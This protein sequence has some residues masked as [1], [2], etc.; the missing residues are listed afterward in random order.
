MLEF[1]PILDTKSAFATMMGYPTMMVSGSAMGVGGSMAREQFGDF[2]IPQGNA[3]FQEV[4]QPMSP[5]N[6]DWQD[7][8]LEEV[9]KRGGGIGERPIEPT[10]NKVYTKYGLPKPEI[11]IAKP[12]KHSLKLNFG[13]GSH[14]NSQGNPW[15]SQFNQPLGALLQFQEQKL[16][17]AGYGFL[18]MPTQA[19]FYPWPHMQIS[20]DKR[21]HSEKGPAIIWGDSKEEYFYR[22]IECPQWLITTPRDELNFDHLSR[23]RNAEHRRIILDFC[24]LKTLIGRGGNKMTIIDK[25]DDGMYE[26]VRITHESQPRIALSMKNPSVDDTHVE[27]VPPDCRTVKDA[28]TYRNDNF[29]YDPVA[30]S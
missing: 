10:I 1:K 5:T 25:S 26:L 24:D 28:L 21:L 14:V 3:Q 6:G 23:C 29:E 16:V 20:K 13:S 11:I 2:L 12:T 18:A 15:V 4:T 22:N 9:A 30:L 17:E 8:V 7:E 19:V 27:W